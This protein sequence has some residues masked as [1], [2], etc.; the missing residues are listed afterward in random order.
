M[1]VS[2]KKNPDTLSP[3]ADPTSLLYLLLVLLFLY[4]SNSKTSSLPFKSYKLYLC[5]AFL[6][7]WK[8]MVS[9]I[10]MY[11]RRMLSNWTCNTHFNKRFLSVRIRFEH[12][13]F[14]MRVGRYNPLFILTDKFERD[15]DNAA[16]FFEGLWNYYLL[17]RTGLLHYNAM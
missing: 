10:F 16:Q 15:S 17:T 11:C 2:K 13:T 8:E 12:S 4:L 14:Q 3:F 5:F 9:F 7:Y 6:F 1:L